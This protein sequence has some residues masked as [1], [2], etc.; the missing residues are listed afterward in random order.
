MKNFIKISNFILAVMAVFGLAFNTRADDT[1]PKAT[2]ATS[3]NVVAPKTNTVGQEAKRPAKQA[4]SASTSATW[5]KISKTDA[6][7][8]SAVDAHA[9]EDALK[10]VDK[11]GGFKGTVTKVFEPRGLAIVEFDENYRNA[12]TAVVRGTNF[13]KFPV[14]TNLVGKDVL[15][16]GKFIKFQDKA[17]IVLDDPKQVKLVE[18]EAK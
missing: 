13:S 4:D 17:E 18:A 14:L 5:G 6:A 11:D 9:L 12:L 3:T 15:V 8:K 10:L 7:Y 2:S 16:T 1:P